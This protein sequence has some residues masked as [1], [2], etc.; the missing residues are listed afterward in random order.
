MDNQNI[1]QPKSDPKGKSIASLK[2]GAINVAILIIPW[3]I[4]APS[5][6][7]Y[8]P[9]SLPGETIASFWTII[10]SP[11]AIILAIW[12]FILGVSGLKSTKRNLAIAGIALSI[13]PP[14]LIIIGGLIIEIWFGW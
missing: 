14:F 1:Q 10:Y 2:I 8:P 9:G 5:F 7:H 11:V 12:G 13:I 3:I 4:M 6:G